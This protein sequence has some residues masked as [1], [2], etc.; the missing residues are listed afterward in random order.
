[1]RAVLIIAGREFRGFL[2]SPLGYALLA[3]YGL[4]AGLL[5]VQLLF[6]FREQLLRSAAQGVLGAA[7]SPAL[8]VH[9]SVVSPYLIH[10]ASLLLFVLPFVTMRSFAEERRARSL[11]VLISYPLTVWQLV[12]GKY[13]GAAGFSLLLVAI[14]ALHLGILALVSTPAALPILGGL[15]GLVLFA[16]ALLAIGLFVSALAVGQVEAAVL[17]LGLF[18]VLAMAGGMTPPDASGLQRAL[19]Q[20]SPL[21]HFLAHARGLL[22]PEGICFFLGV[23]L[24]F[25]A[26][27]IRGVGLIKWRG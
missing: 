1:V 27:A 13:L 25:L 9:A 18:L 17:T 24:L 20:A 12:G 5:F 15:L 26:L 11:E 22:A 2:R 21:Y 3:V 23:T 6:F 19:A 10:A 8:G 16:L 4:A 7:G 14:S